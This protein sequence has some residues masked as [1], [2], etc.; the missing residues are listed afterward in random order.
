VSRNPIREALHALSVEGFVVLEP[1]RGARV[2]SMTPEQVRELFEVR[3]PLEGV[4]ARLAASRRS[5]RDVDR[6]R[7]LVDRGSTAQ[8]DQLPALNT[9]FHS[10]LAG[11]ASNSLL[12]A[13][14]GRLSDIIRWIYAARIRDRSAQSW[15]EH[16]AIV[17]AV[18]DGDELLAERLGIEHI[19]NASAAYETARA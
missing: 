10:A 2:A 16:R 9:E 1:R 13:T 15:A 14:L 6:L 3:G 18:A 8:L 4:V 19:A 17:E 5:T 7:Q 12:T 11:A